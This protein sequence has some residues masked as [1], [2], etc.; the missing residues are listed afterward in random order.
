MKNV[1]LLVILALAGYVGYV[2]WINYQKP[3]P[4]PEVAVIETTPAPA[5]TREEP[6]P[7]TPAP[8]FAPEGV[9]YL[10]AAARV[11][12]ADGIKGLPPGTGVK[13][14][15][16]GI[17]LT[18]AGEVPLDAALLTND[19]GKARAARDADRARQ[20]AANAGIAAQRAIA[21]EQH[22]AEVAAQAMQAESQKEVEVGKAKAAAERQ[23]RID[24]LRKQIAEARESKAYY[25]KI[26]DN[27]RVRDQ[28]AAIRGL[29]QQLSSLG[30]AG[31]FY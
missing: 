31:A 24:D 8:E 12:T 27:A 29:Q 15:K 17:Y 13:L 14:V 6:A 3:R 9:F 11:E 25:Q 1:T 20:A 7:A 28:E 5:L 23:S 2:A 4:A 21:A 19:M 10:I 18:P 22:R 30:V 26:R 16:P